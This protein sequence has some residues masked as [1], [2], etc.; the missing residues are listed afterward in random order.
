M[1][2]ERFFALCKSVGKSPNSVCKELGFSNAAATHWKNRQIPNAKSINKLADYFGVSV[3]YLLG[4]AA[5]NQKAS[6]LSLSEQETAFLKVIR[7]LNA[8]GQKK[9]MDY[10]HDLL[11]SGRYGK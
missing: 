11:S 6:P 4:N 1:F 2:W 3:D 5:E 8:Q 7:A 9:L 10:S